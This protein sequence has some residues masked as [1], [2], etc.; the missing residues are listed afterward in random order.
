MKKNFYFDV[1]IVGC[2]NA[3]VETSYITSYNKLRTLVITNNIDN[4]GVLSC[5]PSIG[6][7][8]KGNLIKEISCLGGIT[9]LISDNSYIQS[10][11]LNK[12][13]GESS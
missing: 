9:G 13:K 12:S 10:K 5:N 1:I 11:I 6:G 4:I 2:G 3:G 7:I 8:C